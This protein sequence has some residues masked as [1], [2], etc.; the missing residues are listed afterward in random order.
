MRGVYQLSLAAAW[1][2]LETCSPHGKRRRCYSW[3]VRYGN[4]QH[5]HRSPLK[6]H[7]PWLWAEQ[8]ITTAQ[9]VVGY[10]M[11]NSLVTPSAVR[12]YPLSGTLR[13]CV[14]LLDQPAVLPAP[15]VGSQKSS[16]PAIS[17]TWARRSA[18][19]LPTIRCLTNQLMSGSQI[20]RTTMRFHML[21]FPIFSSCG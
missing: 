13:K 12:R 18:P 5:L 15:F 20:L 8:P 16:K 14:R 19:M 11:V 17:P 10:P 9:T 1:Q 4:C 21:T 6:L 3:E 7:S 2:R